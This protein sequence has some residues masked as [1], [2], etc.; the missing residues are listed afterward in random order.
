MRSKRITGRP[1]HLMIFAGISICRSFLNPAFKLLAEGNDA[2]LLGIPQLRVKNIL[3]GSMFK[4][5]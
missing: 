4:V 2:R 5:R 1:E 3:V